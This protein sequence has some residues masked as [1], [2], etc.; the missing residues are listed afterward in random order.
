[1]KELVDFGFL[2]RHK[3]QFI[4]TESGKK[5]N[6]IN[7][8]PYDAM[9]ALSLTS[10][11]S[12]EK[13]LDVASS[14][15]LARRVRRSILPFD[16]TPSKILLDWVNEMS[17]DSI[18]SRHGSNYND[19]DIVELG[20]Y[21]SLSLQKISSLISDRKLKKRINILQDRVR[22]GIKTDL[23]ET[24]LMRLPSFSRDNKRALA[25]SFF[26]SGINS[27]NKLAKE[28]PETLV[29]S[30]GISSELASQLVLEAK[31]EIR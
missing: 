30:F 16:I 10:D 31:A 3:S 11:I 24:A 23:A 15:D 26:N 2:K 14:I 25:R 21:T 18:K 5:V 4:I 27:I 12:M 9:I 7:L 20:K 13:L 28:Q 17:L 1:M 6:N 22:Y 19:H 29:K 8:S